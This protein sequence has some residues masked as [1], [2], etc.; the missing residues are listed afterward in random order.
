[1][2]SDYLGLQIKPKKDISGCKV[3]WLI[4]QCAARE[5]EKGVGKTPSI[6]VT[7]F[8]RGVYRLNTITRRRMIQPFLKNAAHDTLDSGLDVT[9]R[10]FRNIYEQLTARIVLLEDR[11]L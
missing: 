11:V 8:C 7:F 4:L 9:L 10:Q 5:S 1:M 3:D 2:R 6:S